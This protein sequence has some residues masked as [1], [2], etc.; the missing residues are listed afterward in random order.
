MGVKCPRKTNRWVHLGN[1]LKFLK[2][3][4]RR[5]MT[6]I[7]ED[8]PDMLPTDAWWTVTYAIAPGID[9][10]NIAFALL[11]NRSLLMAQQESHIMAL[12]ATISTMFDLELIDPD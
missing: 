1:V 2:E 9:A 4:R 11:Q 5:L 10:I 7:E 3:N 6:Y 12:V 8:R